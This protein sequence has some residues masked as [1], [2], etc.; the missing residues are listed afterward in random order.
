[1]EGS[2]ERE[3]V[4]FDLEFLGSD[5]N[6]YAEIAGA[7]VP[8]GRLHASTSGRIDTALRYAP[9]LEPLGVADEMRVMLLR[10]GQVWGSLTLYRK[11]GARPFS[12]D[13]E[14]IVAAAAPH[15]AE[16]FRL[17]MLRTALAT[18]SG[19]DEPPGAVLLGP[20]GR[21]ERTEQAQ[22]WLSLIDDRGRLPSVARALASA[23]RSDGA[24]HS[25]AVPTPSGR[26]VALHASVVANDESVVVIIEGARTTVLSD[27]IA[28][29][30][31]FTTREREIVAMTARGASTRQMAQDL[32]ISPFTA[33]DHLKSIF[34]KA[35]V[36]SRGELI[37][38]LFNQ[39]YRP[40]G[41]SG[42]TPSPYGWYLDDVA[43]A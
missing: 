28:E 14:R 40:R 7:A 36:H 19:L 21:V 13:E 16:L 35:G 18:P 4:I 2:D 24:T 34:A 9:L 26:W 15:M 10:R 37:A 41:Q 20:D 32:A 39:H 22:R 30:H 8:V 33:A 5:V 12:A 17:T 42:A 11:V 38:L 25:V 1:L 31:G 27:V 3:T 6:S 29:A 23:A 43:T